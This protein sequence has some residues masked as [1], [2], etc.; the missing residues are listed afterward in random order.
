MAMWPK[1]Q[2]GGDGK[3]VFKGFGPNWDHPRWALKMLKP[4][5]PSIKSIFTVVTWLAL[6]RVR[7]RKKKRAESENEFI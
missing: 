7:Q 3:K 6:I 2:T 5:R 4:S 1:S